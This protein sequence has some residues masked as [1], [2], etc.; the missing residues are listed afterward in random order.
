MS[1]LRS[2]FIPKA[3]MFGQRKNLK[4]TYSVRLRARCAVRR[5]A[6]GPA[7]TIEHMRW[8]PGESGFETAVC[9]ERNEESLT[10]PL[11]EAGCGLIHLIC[12]P[13]WRSTA[14]SVKRQVSYMRRKGAYEATSKGNSPEGV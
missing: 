5:Y 2:N 7:V 13:L 4:A 6:L 11:T 14:P 8:F 3:Q 12:L 10:F 1:S 9:A